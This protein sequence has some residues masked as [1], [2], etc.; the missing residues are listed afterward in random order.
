MSLKRKYLP[1]C[2]WMSC[3]VTLSC[4]CF[5]VAQLGPTLCTS[6]DCSTPVFLILHCLSEFTQNHVPWVDDA[7]QPSHALSPLLLLPSV[8]PSIKVFSNTS[9]FQWVISSHQV[10]KVLELQHQSF[11]WIL[12]VNF[13]WDW[14]VWSPYSPRNSQESSPAPQFL[15]KVTLKTFWPPL[16]PWK[17]ELNTSCERDTERDTEMPSIAKREE[18]NS[19]WRWL[20]K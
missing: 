19:G 7:N 3:S 4:C 8:F 20:C 5:S 16:S 18:K 11:L 1:G 14:L 15:T 13:L 12:R 6:M 17:L 2:G 10:A 9:T